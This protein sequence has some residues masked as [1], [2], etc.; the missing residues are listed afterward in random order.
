MIQF[1]R[2]WGLSALLCFSGNSN[3]AVL[4]E[5]DV[6]LLYHRYEGGGM[7]IDGPSV[8]IRKSM[9][10]QVSV[11]ANYYVDKV[12]SASVDVLATASPYREERTE[13]SVGVDYLINKG[14]VSL[15]FTDS[16]ESD[17]AAQSFHFDLSQDF[18]GDLTTLNIGYSRGWDEVGKTGA[19]NFSEEADRRH[20]RMGLTQVL[21]KTALLTFS[22]E[23]I[24][25]EG[26]LNNPYRQVRF[27]VQDEGGDRVDY[28]D[29]VYPHTRTSN[30]LAVKATHYLPY[31]A[32]LSGQYRFFTDSWGIRAHTAELAYVH[33]FEN[34]WILDLKY[35]YYQQ[36]SADFYQ[37]LF[38]YRDA[39]NFLARDKELSRFS[40]NSIG[41]GIS[42]E[43]PETAWGQIDSGTI[44]ILYDYMLFDYDD[45]RNAVRQDLAPGTEPLYSFN[46]DVTRLLLNLRY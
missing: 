37:D 1:C 21:S 15:S 39:Q 11:N 26:Y 27:L 23:L 41:L 14:T 22:Y 31:R 24:S 32:A 20:Y 28:Q 33:P 44:S 9:G 18:F 34:Q 40:S 5:D 3:S 45:F 12:S 19:V 35:R 7:K 16:D 42:Y 8:L 25:D 6:S 10:S 46:A 43:F 29:E 2:V 36:T 4:P 38:P 13:I 30:A 17:F